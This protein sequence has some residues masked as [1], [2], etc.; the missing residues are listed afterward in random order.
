MSFLPA[1]PD[2]KYFTSLF[3]PASPNEMKFHVVL[4]FAVHLLLFQPTISI[5]SAPTNET[6]R[7]ALLKFKE[8]VSHDPYNLLSSWNASSF[9][10]CNWLGITCGRRHQRVTALDLHGCNLRGS[11]SPYIGNLTFLRVVNLGNNNFYGEIP[12][13]VGHLFRLQHLNFSINTLRGEIPTSVT[14][15]LELRSMDMFSNELIGNIPKQLG[16]LQKLEL[17]N[18]KRN[19]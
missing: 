13:E 9:H 10:F 2:T 19:N 15:C 17:M 3:L 16:P 14:N 1:L 7:L 18:L 11:I 6:D 8:S 5:V 12:Q 4:L